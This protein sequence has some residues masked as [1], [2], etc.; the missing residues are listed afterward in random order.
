MHYCEPKSLAQSST[1]DADFKAAKMIFP[2]LPINWRR[3]VLERKADSACP[4]F[5]EIADLNVHS[6]RAQREPSPVG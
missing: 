6:E 1:Y 3:S 5:A 4:C 2:A